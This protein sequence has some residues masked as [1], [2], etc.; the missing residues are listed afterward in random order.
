MSRK[1]PQWVN[2]MILANETESE[3]FTER[4]EKFKAREIAEKL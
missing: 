4:E 2:H 1:K 3:I